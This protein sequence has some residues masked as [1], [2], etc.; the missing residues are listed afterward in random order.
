VRGSLALCQS[1]WEE[2]ATVNYMLA[3]LGDHYDDGFGAMGLSFSYA[4]QNL[5]K[6]QEGTR[7]FF[8]GH[9]PINFLF[10]HSIELFLKSGIIILHRRLEIP[11]GEEP[12]TGVPFVP[13]AEK[14]KA[15]HYVHSIGTLY[16]HWKELI[17]ADAVV[18]KK[19]CKFESAD[20]NIPEKLTVCVGIIDETDSTSTY[21]RYPDPRDEAGD[22]AK[23]NFKEVPFDE[24][25]P[26]HQLKPT[27]NAVVILGV[28]NAA[29]EFVRG[30]KLD[31]D[32]EKKATYALQ[33]ANSWL[34]NFHAMMRMELTEGW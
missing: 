21:Y 28:Q 15:Y 12:Y 17:E 32:T 24:L 33:Y 13:V 34:T 30:Y 26:Q 7:D 18:L 23:S 3:P 2:F 8:L 9:M 1:G 29:G 22:I 5:L 6:A 4:A 19:M 10:R 20:W 25:F 27:E 14:W 16:A 11:Y 31:D